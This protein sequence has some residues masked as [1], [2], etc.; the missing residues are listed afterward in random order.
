[1]NKLSE[2][3]DVIQKRDKIKNNLQAMRRKGLIE[4]EGKIWKLSSKV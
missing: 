4:V 2:G 1:M 3:L